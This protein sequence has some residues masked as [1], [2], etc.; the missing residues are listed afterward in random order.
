M[1][2]NLSCL[3][4]DAWLDKPIGY[5]NHSLAL[6]LHTT[7]DD[8]VDSGSGW[9]VESPFLCYKNYVKLLITEV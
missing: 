7:P 6:C 1:F 5:L 8:R 4:W 3:K 9:F 2:C